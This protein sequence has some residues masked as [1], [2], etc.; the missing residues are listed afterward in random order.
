MLIV[1]TLGMD[2]VVMSGAVARD[3]P[4]AMLIASECRGRSHTTAGPLGIL[5]PE[6]PRIWGLLTNR[7]P[8]ASSH[9][10]QTACEGLVLTNYRKPP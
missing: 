6:P 3:I 10:Y 5:S 7:E 1:L 4:R 9:S 8:F 2:A